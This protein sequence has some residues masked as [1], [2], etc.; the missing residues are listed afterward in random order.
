MGPKEMIEQMIDRALPKGPTLTDLKLQYSSLE[1]AHAAALSLVL[2]THPSLQSLTQL[3][4]FDNCIGDDGAIALAKALETNSSITTVSLGSNT[5]GD[6]GATALADALRTNISIIELHLYKNNIGDVGAKALAEALTLN[7]S[8]AELY[9]W[10]NNIERDGATALAQA[11]ATNT[12]ITSLHLAYNNIDKS[13]YQELRSVASRPNRTIVLFGN[14]G[15]QGYIGFSSFLEMA[16]AISFAFLPSH[17]PT[18]AQ[19]QPN[20]SKETAIGR[21]ESI[22]DLL[23]PLHRTVN[24]SVGPPATGKSTM[25]RVACGGSPADPD[26]RESTRGAQLLIT[27][28]AL[29]PPAGSASMA[30]LQHATATPYAYIRHIATLALRE[31]FAQLFERASRQRDEAREGHAAA[32]ASQPAP[33]QPPSTSD[34]AA[35]MAATPPPAPVP[36]AAEP[37]PHPVKEHIEKQLENLLTAHSRPPSAP[38]IRVTFY[39]IGGQ[40]QFESVI[41]PLL[42]E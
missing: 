7:S 18:I 21:L 23:I 41:L 14:P 24:F 12:S 26:I 27:E 8:I 13:G 17:R 2:N 42:R 37:L 1:D 36:T 39:D 4:L 28:V 29:S 15:A 30:S 9:L 25:R 3:H 16:S 6:V 31:D 20:I 35:A 33:A 32:D 11:L 10:R 19:H 5:I 38:R 22:S 34:S 40:R